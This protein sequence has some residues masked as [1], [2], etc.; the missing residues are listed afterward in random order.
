MRELR[1]VLERAVLFCGGDVLE[2]TGQLLEESG[3]PQAALPQSG[4]FWPMRD[5]SSPIDLQKELERLEKAYIDKAL[6]L[7]GNN[8]SQA[9]KLLGYSRF[10]LRRRLE[11]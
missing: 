2:H 1:N 10:S 6:R 11:Q 8:Y 9:A 3:A 4:E 7:T 5:L